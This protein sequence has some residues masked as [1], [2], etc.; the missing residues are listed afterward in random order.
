MKRDSVS[1]YA[2]MKCDTPLPL[3]ASVNIFDDPSPPPPPLPSILLVTYIVVSYALYGGFF[4]KKSSCLVTRIV[5]F[6][7]IKL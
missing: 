3:Y 1:A 5:S 2:H 4:T 6:D 7:A